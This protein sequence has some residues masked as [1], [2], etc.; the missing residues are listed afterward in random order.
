[1][2][3]LQNYRNSAKEL[4][5]CIPGTS[6]SCDTDTTDQ[7][8]VWLVVW[9]NSLTVLLLN[10]LVKH[11]GAFLTDKSLN[12]EE[13]VFRKKKTVLYSNYTLNQLYSWFI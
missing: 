6:P 4:N 7:P 3:D 13:Y 1:M 10:Y 2:R 11:I 8:S 5:P 9:L 12:S